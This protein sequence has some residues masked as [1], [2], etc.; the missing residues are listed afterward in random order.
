MVTTEHSTLTT[1]GAGNALASAIQS[2]NIESSQQEAIS[3]M[4]DMVHE[5]RLVGDLISMDY[6]TAEVLIHD[7]M[8]RQVSGV[9]L[10]CL[11]IATRMKPGITPDLD[12]PNSRFILL[13]VLGSSKLPNDIEVQLNRINAAKRASERDGRGEEPPLNY[14]EGNITDTLTLHQ[15][16]FSGTHCRIVGTYYPRINPQTGMCEIAF[17]SDIDNFYAGQGMKIYKPAGDGLHRI[18]NY[19]KPESTEEG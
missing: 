11:L 19:T 3:F 18:V 15:M 4:S 5:D 13:R 10:G 12:D 9:P 17:G 2:H 14:D 1:N 8:K 6:E 7:S 16:R